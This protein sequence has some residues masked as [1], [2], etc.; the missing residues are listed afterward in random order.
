MADQRRTDFLTG[1]SGDRR[2]FFRTTVGRLATEIGKRAEA[3]VVQQRYLRPPGA[4]DPVPFLAACTRC[5]ACIDACPVNAIVKAPTSAGLAAGTPMIDPLVRAC[6]ACETM[7]CAA[8]CPTDALTV[9]E[10]GWEGYRM[11]ELELNPDRC[12]AFYGSQCGV[13][14]R[15]CPVGERAISLDEKGRPVIKWEGC[16]GC[17]SCVRACVTS[18]PS[19]SLQ[20]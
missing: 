11:A 6:V 16:V 12:I 3:R 15:S 7:P 17:G 4:L 13:C 5:A 9:P 8:E 10:H 14:A 20:Y 1:E 2:S 19:L 18:P